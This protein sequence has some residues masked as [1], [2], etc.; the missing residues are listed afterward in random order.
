[1]RFFLEVGNKRY[2]TASELQKFPR[3]STALSPRAGSISLTHS[4]FGA[5]VSVSL[6]ST[7]PPK[8]SSSWPQQSHNC[9]HSAMQGSLSWITRNLRL[10]GL[11]EQRFPSAVATSR[12]LILLGAGG[13]GGCPSTGGLLDA[14]ELSPTPA[15][16][17]RT[18]Q[19][20][21]SIRT[22]RFILE[23]LGEGQ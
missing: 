4:P 23:T 12:I 11:P 16:T 10:P 21:R 15:Q 5:I 2:Q 19:Q 8:R 9:R 22:V 1:R 20:H 7:V 13:D 17:A 18:P 14:H 6:S 3:T